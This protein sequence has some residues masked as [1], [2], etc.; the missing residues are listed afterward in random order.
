ML[1]EGRPSEDG[2]VLQ[3]GTLGVNYN[4]KVSGGVHGSLIPALSDELAAAA[5]MAAMP[6]PL[7]TRAKVKQ[8]SIN[9]VLSG[10]WSK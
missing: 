6:F 9:C 5:A 7:P 10:I 1:Q 8:P 3:A 2:T 4:E